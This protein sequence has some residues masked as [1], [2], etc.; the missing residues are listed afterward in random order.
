MSKFGSKRYSKAYDILVKVIRHFKKAKFKRNRTKMKNILSLIIL[1]GL[2]M[3]ASCGKEPPPPVD[4][5]TIQLSFRAIYDG[6][7]LV[8]QKEY[9]YQGSIVRFSRINFYLANL[10]AANDDGETELSEIQ[11]ID[12][13]LTHNTLPDAEKGTVMNFSRIP[14]GTYN[15]LRFG[16]GVPADLNK[17]TPSDYSTSHPLG[18]DNSA[19]YWE[20]WN[21]YIFAKIEGQFDEDGSGDFDG[22][23][24]SFAYHTGTDRVYEQDI[25]FDNV[26]NLNGGET[27]NLD[28]ELDIK[29]LLSF[30]QGDSFDLKPHDPNNLGDMILIMENFRRALQLK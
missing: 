14:V 11:F 6:E 17:T 30:K 23:D 24:I 28:F 25:E 27:T 9:E 2:L 8:L 16:V 29:T 5:A 15:L 12:L 22:N 10:V 4:T 7:P 13:S 26:L 1:A 19:E 21:S 18:I 3:A 20:A